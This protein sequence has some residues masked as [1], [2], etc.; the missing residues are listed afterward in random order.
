MKITLIEEPADV[1]PSKILPYSMMGLAGLIVLYS[2]T[3]GSKKEEEKPEE[4]LEE[5][6]EVEEEEK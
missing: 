5:E 3:S 1:T 6:A 2:F 4:E